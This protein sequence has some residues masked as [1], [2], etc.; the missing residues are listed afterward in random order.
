M[1]RF[2]CIYI[3]HVKMSSHRVQHSVHCAYY[4]RPFSHRHSRKSEGV[5]DDINNGSILTVMHKTR[6]KQ[7]IINFIIYTC[8]SLCEI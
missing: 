5:T 8:A 6:T 2:S 3:V 1:G 4:N 7:L